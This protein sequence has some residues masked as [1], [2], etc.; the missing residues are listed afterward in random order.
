VSGA[1]VAAVWKTVL[2][3]GLL[4]V[5]G[6]LCALSVLGLLVMPNLMDRLHFL[7]PVTSAAAPVVA[8]AVVARESLSHA[9]IMAVLVAVVLLVLSPVL[10]HATARADRVRRLGDWRAQPK[11]KV[12]RP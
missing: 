8:G 9:G 4:L 6:V 5:A 1:V 3:D 12:R 7:T 11:E 2:V 10:T